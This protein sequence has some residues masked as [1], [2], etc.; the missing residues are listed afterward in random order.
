MV[1]VGLGGLSEMR[2]VGAETSVRARSFSQMYAFLLPPARSRDR[3]LRIR[4]IDSR[5]T[6]GALQVCW[7]GWRLVM[8]FNV[9]SFCILLL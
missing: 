8:Y 6:P 2:R 3:S 4:A 5:E 7:R 1:V 9:Y